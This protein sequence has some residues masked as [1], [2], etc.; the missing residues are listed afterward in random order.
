MKTFI[1]VALG[2]AFWLFPLTLIVL[3]AIKLGTPQD[4]YGFYY[5]GYGFSYASVLL[6]GTPLLMIALTTLLGWLARRGRLAGKTIVASSVLAVLA[7]FAWCAT[8]YS[9]V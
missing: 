6:F 8:F 4:W 9:G 7:T 3:L 5:E 2:C 1:L